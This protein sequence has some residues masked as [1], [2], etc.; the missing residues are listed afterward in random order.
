MISYKELFFVVGTVFWDINNVHSIV[1]NY[2]TSTFDIIESA[3]IK[4]ERYSFQ[5][6]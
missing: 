2:L 3:Y 1:N 5:P 4:A 6:H